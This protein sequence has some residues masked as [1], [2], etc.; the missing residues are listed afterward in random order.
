MPVLGISCAAMGRPGPAET[1]E[2]RKR[3]SRT[4]RD[5]HLLGKYFP[6]ARFIRSMKREESALSCPG[7]RGN[8][9]YNKAFE[10]RN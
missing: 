3:H 10:G 1:A 4:I 2:G 9:S 6:W 5:A 7:G 8:H